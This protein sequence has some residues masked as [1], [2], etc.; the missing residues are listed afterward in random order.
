MERST[1]AA[2]DPMIRSTFAEPRLEASV[3][4]DG[5]CVVPFL[6]PDAL[7]AVRSVYAELGRAPDDPA[8]AV[9]FGFFSEDSVWKR[10]VREALRP[11]VAPLVA[12]HFDD[13]RL[14]YAMFITKWPGDRSAFG[15]HRDPW[16]VDE[17][18]FRSITLWCPLVDTPPVGGP[19]NGTLHFVPGSHRFTTAPRIHD[20]S[21][22]I[23]E[24]AQEM[25]LE[26]A[27]YPVRL[28]AGDAVTFDNGMIHY[29]YRNASPAPRTVL[30]LGLVPREAQLYYLQQEHPG[31]ISVYAVD[32]DYFIEHNPF[33]IAFGLGAY[34]EVARLPHRPMAVTRD[35]FR[36]WCRQTA[37]E[38]DPE[39]R[40]A[41]VERPTADL[42]TD[43]FCFL[44]GASEGLEGAEDPEHASVMMVCPTCASAVSAR[45][46]SR[47]IPISA[48]DPDAPPAPPLG[49]RDLREVTAV[50]D[51]AGALARSLAERGYAVVPATPGS[52]AA[53]DRLRQVADSLG[54]LRPVVRAVEPAPDAA[55][56][57]QPSWTVVDEAEGQHS[58]L[59]WTAEA[60]DGPVTIT[61]VPRTHRL[62]GAPR[63][64]GF[65]PQW[66]AA[67]EVLRHA[68][69][70]QVG[71][72]DVLVVDPAL[73]HQ[74]L[75]EPV[76]GAG[77]AWLAVARSAAAD[78]V[79][80]RRLVDGRVARYEVDE[81]LLATARLYGDAELPSVCPVRIYG[82]HVE[83]P[84]P[85][86]VR[87]DLGPLAPPGPPEA[88]PAPSSVGHRLASR[89]RRLLRRPPAARPVPR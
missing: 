8:E 47:A 17:T 10:E 23:F 13:H 46:T 34:E 5:Y 55:P 85:E 80:L 39:L 31:S 24:G 43:A 2:V 60:P 36:T 22:T 86:R 9:H 29:S 25:I 87:A 74:P 28:R 7:A 78:V 82:S 68:E 14:A 16:F 20:A 44:C 64:P 45:Y 41:P 27:S 35:E 42:S 83:H 33:S 62:D 51:A 4:R 89:A 21:A 52:G 11:I 59:L 6:D 79:H 71:P 56:V 75:T 37:S 61:V 81:A 26:E 65:H 19:D 84:S 30:A 67:P 77:R 69:P 50:P 1:V 72:G 63:G 66:H 15:P 32:S 53:A 58:W 49:A 57:L 73:V 88:D 70:V 12:E 3:R 76:A 38:M 40:L 18:R 48:H 54:D